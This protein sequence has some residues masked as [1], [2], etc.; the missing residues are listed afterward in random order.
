MCM[1]KQVKVVVKVKVAQSCPT[2]RD[3]RDYT[4]HGILQV[5]TLEW[6]AFPFARGSSQPR[7]RT[8][9]QYSEVGVIVLRVL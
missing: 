4:V 9:V 1:E 3:P 6:A 5:R 8:Q 7:D 2:L